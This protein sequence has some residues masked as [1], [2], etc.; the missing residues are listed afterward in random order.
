[1][2]DN[3][4][5]LNI[6]FDIEAIIEAYNLAVEKIGFSGNLV[7]CISLTHK[8][9]GVNDQRGVFWT[10]NEDYKEVQVERFVN[11][12]AYK[13]FEP[14]LYETYL[15]NVYDVLSKHFKLGRIRILKLGSRT[16]LSFHRDPEA[17]IH[18]PIITNPGALMVVNN[19]AFH[20][21]ANG[22]AYFVDTTKYHT[23]LNGG[24]VERVHLVA[25][26]LDD[27]KEEELYTI[28]GGD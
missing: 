9:S 4:R 5:K 7:N 17:R 2:S 26:I 21:P 25:T 16:S 22:S 10:M 13:V 28:Y 6:H 12:D 3:F 24:N 8:N 18:I 20:M 15:K 23:A 27:N 1:M 11:E 14:L 19:E